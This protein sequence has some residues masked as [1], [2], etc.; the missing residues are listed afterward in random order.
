MAID[1]RAN[2]Q[3]TINTNL[4]DNI[5]EDITPA[6]H[7]EV[8][9]DLNDSQFNK[10]DEPRDISTNT[11]YVSPEGNNG[12]AKTGDQSSPYLT[13]ASLTPSIL[14]D[15]S[16]VSM[17]GSFNESISITIK[18][19]FRLDLSNTTIV[20]NITLF[21]VNNYVLDLK[22]ASVIGNIIIESCTNGVIDLRGATVTGNVEFRSCNGGTVELSG[23]KING[24][25][26][27]NTGSTQKITV[28]GGEI[29]GGA[30][31]GLEI[32]ENCKINHVIIN[33]TSAAAVQGPAVDN[34]NKS[35][36]T[37]CTISSTNSVGVFAV[38]ACTFNGGTIKG[39]RA[40]EDSPSAFTT[41]FNGVTLIGTS[42]EAIKGNNS[43]HAFC[44]NCTIVSQVAGFPN[45]E[46]GN[47][48]ERTRFYN[49]RFISESDCIEILTVNIQ[50]TGDTTVFQ[51]CNF[52][53]NQSGGG[54]LVFNDTSGAY[55]VDTGTSEFIRNTYA[56]P[57]S[58]T[59]GTRAIDTNSSV[60]PLLP[61]PY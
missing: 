36:F 57:W 46:M 60:R 9:T 45:V 17:G 51:D 18:N 42:E 21:V 13:F 58:T 49:C 14:D 23:G 43:L 22:G 24:T 47:N 54:G 31:V 38:S 19:N 41:E 4:P 50:R 12:T 44:T 39:F 8:E 33:S 27:L 15:S 52:Y 28:N 35:I 32:G 56:A 2:N 61:D 16:V 55:A 5:T 6:L 40:F 11:I 59:D 26:D 29:L 1:S 7:R 10:I 30:G 37:G 48:C 25:L 34:N 3:I 53:P 20:G